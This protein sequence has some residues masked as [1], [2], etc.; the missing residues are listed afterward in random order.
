MTHMCMVTWA[1]TV[2]TVKLIEIRQI[3][4]WL[5]NIV[6]PNIVYLMQVMHS[7]NSLC[8]KLVNSVDI[9]RF[10]L[11]EKTLHISLNMQITN[12]IL[13]KVVLQKVHNVWSIVKSSLWRF[14]L[15]CPKI[16]IEVPTPSHLP[17]PWPLPK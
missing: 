16:L 13:I 2:V 14:N 11:I 15:F 17:F 6:Q 12:I 10:H 3:L 4:Y 9:F 5:Q 8:I 1:I 7:C